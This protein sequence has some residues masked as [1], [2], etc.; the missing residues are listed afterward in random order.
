MNCGVQYAMRDDVAALER[1]PKL[2]WHFGRKKL[3]I[4]VL[5][6]SELSAHDL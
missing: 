1:S 3:T 5:V 4:C 6:Q 2:R